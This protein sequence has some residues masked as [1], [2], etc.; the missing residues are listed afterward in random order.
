VCGLLVE[1]HQLDGVQHCYDPTDSSY[2]CQEKQG[3]DD[4]IMAVVALIGVC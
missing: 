1:L 2:D 3:H 4:V